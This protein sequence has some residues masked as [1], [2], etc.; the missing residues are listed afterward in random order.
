[1]QRGWNVSGVMRVLAFGIGY[2]DRSVSAMAEIMT[3]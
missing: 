1:V 2:V 3:C